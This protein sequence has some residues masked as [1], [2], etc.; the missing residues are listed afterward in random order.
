MDLQQGLT[1]YEEDHLRIKKR[2]EKSTIILVSIVLIFLLC[3]MFRFSLKAYEV[4]HPSQ[5]TAKH[6]S[7]C[8]MQGK[9]HIPVVLYGLMSASNVLIVFNSSVNF[10]IYCLVEESFR[11]KLLS[12]LSS[13]CK[14]LCKMVVCCYGCIMLPFYCSSGSKDSNASSNGPSA[15]NQIVLN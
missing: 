1:K 4:T 13:W 9:F 6:H 3:H 11:S 10:I 2:R 7:Y 12:I 5:I 14:G 15:Q 8:L